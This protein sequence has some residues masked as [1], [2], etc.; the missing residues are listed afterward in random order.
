MNDQK[1]ALRAGDGGEGLKV[2]EP[3]IKAVKTEREGESFHLVF[4]FLDLS[5][6]C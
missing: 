4:F 3:R 5:C 6:N 2:A 1:R